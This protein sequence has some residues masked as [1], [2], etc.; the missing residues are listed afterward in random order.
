MR[1]S[2]RLAGSDDYPD[3]IVGRFSAQTAAHVDTQV[4]RT[5][6]SPSSDDW[7]ARLD[8]RIA[9]RCGRSV[10]ATKSQRGPLTV[11]RAF[12]PEGGVCHL[13][14]LHPPGG[15]VGGDRLE[16][17]LEVGDLVKVTVF[18]TRAE[19][20]PLYR[21]V[22]DRMLEGAEPASTLLIVKGLA[23]PDFLVEIEAIAAA[24]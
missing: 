16:I 13:Y 9:Q 7:R 20:T 11:Q 23:S 6:A 15:V 10:L 24:N 3:I 4:E 17:D 2:S 8:L 21:Q 14:L 18:L 22:R 12:Y 19:D 1:S 5:I